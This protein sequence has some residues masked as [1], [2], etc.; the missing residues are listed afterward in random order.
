MS[1]IE[2]QSMAAAGE[3]EIGGYLELLAAIGQDFAMSLDIDET[4]HLALQ[5]ILETGYPLRS[6]IPYIWF[7]RLR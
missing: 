5:R 3:E 6:R 4:L 1:D 7:P 2:L